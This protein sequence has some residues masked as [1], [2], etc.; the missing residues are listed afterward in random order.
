[1]QIPLM[2]TALAMSALLNVPL[3]QTV[4]IGPEQT[5]S[6]TAEIKADFVLH[7]G[8][9]T[10]NGAVGTNSVEALDYSYALGYRYMEID[11][12]WTSDGRLA[13]VHDWES[14]YPIG[15]VPSAAEFETLRT[16]HGFTSLTLPVLA[17]WMRAHPDVR[18]ITDVKENNV[19][20]ARLISASCPD[21]LDRFVVQIYNR[22]QNEP[23]RACGF[24]HIWL[25]LYQLPWNIKTDTALLARYAEECDLEALV[26]SCELVP[27]TGY[28]EQLRGIGIPLYAHTVNTKEEQDALRAAGIDGIYTDTGDAYAK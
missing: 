21:L 8:G 24:T 4:P 23:V 26:F 20:A 10:P 11:F 18:I 3:P 14:W 1:M 28:V 19:E 15:H 7:A 13:C 2:L 22:G 16:T 12:C 27:R 25:T 5:E 17:D 9:V 6:S